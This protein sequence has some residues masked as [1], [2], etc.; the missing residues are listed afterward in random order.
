MSCAEMKDLMAVVV[1]VDV[2]CEV[3]YTGELK[4][5]GFILLLLVVVIF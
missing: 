1:V 5:K 2:I 3:A 4:Q